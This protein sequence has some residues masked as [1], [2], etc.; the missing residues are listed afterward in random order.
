[1]HSEMIGYI[2][3]RRLIGIVGM[4]FPLALLVTV[5][6]M[7]GPVPGSISDYYYS[8]RVCIS[9]LE[10]SLGLIGGFLLCYRGYDRDYI[11]VRIAGAAML[12]VVFFPT[13]PAHPTH[14]NN[15]VGIFHGISAATT[16]ITLAY[17]SFFLFTKT[18][19]PYKSHAGTA[20][21][22]WMV[23][24]KMTARKRERNVIYR[25]C[26][27]V[28]AAAMVMIFLNLRW[29]H[30]PYGMYSLEWIIVGAFAFSWLVKGKTIL[31]DK[32]LETPKK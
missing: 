9:I 12:L 31:R 1:M 5:L 21:T 22:N 32:Q 17:I 20:A 13:I 2:W 4:A 27:I 7:G 3:L 10:C 30:V 24:P 28:M 23:Y 15:I 18:E 6:I 25:T 11:P 16:F 19:K 8:N 26:G 29:F 14:A